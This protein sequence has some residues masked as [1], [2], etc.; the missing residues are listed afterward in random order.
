[1]RLIDADKILTGIE[2]I[3]ISPWATESYMFPHELAVKEALEIVRD[4]CVNQAPTVDAV[5]VVRCKECVHRIIDKDF[6]SGHY[7]TLRHFN[8]GRFCEDNDF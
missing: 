8:G 4:L 7:C 1:M 6:M 5:I 3:K 2:E